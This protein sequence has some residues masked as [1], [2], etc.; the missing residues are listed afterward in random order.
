MTAAVVEF[1]SSRIRV[2]FVLDRAAPIPAQWRGRTLWLS[3]RLMEVQL[4]ASA[5]RRD[6]LR[7]Y[8]C[9]LVQFRTLNNHCRRCGV[10]L[11]RPE[12]EALPPAVAAPAP[13]EEAL[14]DLAGAIRN[15]RRRQGLSQRELAQ[16][17][18]VPRT[19]VSKIENDKATPTLASLER[20]AEAMETCVATFLRT[21]GTGAPMSHVQELLADSFI[22]ELIPYIPRLAPQQMRAVLSQM[23]QWTGDGRAA[24]AGAGI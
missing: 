12:P 6:V 16:R 22:Q 7:C 10:G 14:P 21:S 1:E 23:R 5:E 15:L 11:D 13:P 24:A 19:Y 3:D 4:V 9:S 2:H 8:S 17:M 20:L 18:R